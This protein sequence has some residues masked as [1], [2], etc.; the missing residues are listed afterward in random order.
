[1][2][3]LAMWPF[4]LWHSLLFFLFSLIAPVCAKKA[5]SEGDD[6]A[7]LF[8][9]L[10][11][12]SCGLVPWTLWVLWYLLFPGRAEVNKAF[13]VTS[14]HGR[15][16]FCR[17]QAM[18]E[19][20]E[21]DIRKLKTR[22]ISVGFGA[23]LVLLALLWCWLVYIMMQ[24]RQ[25][26]ATSALY[27]NFDPY[28]ILEVGGTSSS[29]QIKKAFHKLSLKYHPD[30]NPDAAAAEK[31]ILI[32][33]AYDALTDPV[34]KRNY[35]LYGN[36]DGPTRVELSVTLPTV[37]KEKQGLVLVLF[38]VP[39]V[40]GVPL[41]LLYCMQ[42]SSV[43]PNGLPPLT[44][45]VLQN[46]LGE[47]LDVRAA[48][49]LLLLASQPDLPPE[50]MVHV[51]A[52]D[53]ADVRRQLACQGAGHVRKRPQSRA[54]DEIKLQQAE[55]LF[56][57]HV[58]RRKDL[59]RDL[60]L[61]ESALREWEKTCKALLQLAAKKGY[62]QTLQST[63]DVFR[64]LVQ[65]IDPFGKGAGCSAGSLLQI[66]H[67]SSEQTRLWQKR[68]KKYATLPTF[69]SMPSQERSSALSAEDIGFTASQR[70]DIDEFVACAPQMQIQAARV[71]VQGEDEICIGDVATLELR[72]LRSNLQEGQAVG[73][74]HTPLFPSAQVRE[75]WWVTFR[76]PGRGKSGVS[77]CSRITDPSREVVAHIRFR[78]P[79]A[80]K[81][82]L[83]L[84]LSCESYVG[85]DMEEVVDYVAKQAV[86][87]EPDDNGES[88]SEDEDFDE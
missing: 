77:V 88:G 56:W 82:R 24:V 75:A 67:F 85:L 50:P 83:R 47:A 32:K 68:H 16:R 39:F 40:I 3:T 65:A 20:Q 76:L 12:L 87:H 61:L 48:Q 33:K 52:I 72:L 41:M 59:L 1:M 78:V 18:Q 42:S 38:L 74:A 63:L 51:C 86:V 70:A 22:Q 62:S 28:A 49:E 35:R 44:N 34:A 57:G 81:C 13:P 8:F 10:A 66:P 7:M 21:A 36:P 27:Q 11:M 30:K 6:S 25:V 29:S 71:F 46:G 55:V 19:R 2:F 26:L 14:E 64:G 69:L 31:F 43:D 80:G 5:S 23:R 84:T 79:L 54:K 9:L 45:E 58:L 17:T 37:D 4:L 15:T 73:Y 60:D 53:Y